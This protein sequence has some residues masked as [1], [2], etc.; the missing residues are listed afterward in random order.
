LVSRIAR[1]VIVVSLK[2]IAPETSER[3]RV[4]S[5]FNQQFRAG[6]VSHHARACIRDRAR[7]QA[8]ALLLL[9][10]VM[11]DEIGPRRKRR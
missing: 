5:S 2:P 1:T 6:F 9:E 8:Y 4:S 3:H 11:M 10:L 7:R